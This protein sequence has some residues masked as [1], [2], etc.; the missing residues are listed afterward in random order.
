M[1]RPRLLDKNLLQKV[2]QKLGKK[3]IK[4]INVMVSQKASNLGI[5]PEAALILIAKGLN[6][7]T[8]AYQ[9]K[10]NPYKQVEV[11]DMLP[12][13]FTE[14]GHRKAVKKNFAYKKNST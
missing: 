14:K 3:D 11:R 4:R 1:A 10:L 7:G 13:L 12:T 6:I 5:S 9:R 2:C 8:S